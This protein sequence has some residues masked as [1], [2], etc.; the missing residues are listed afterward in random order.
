MLGTNSAQKLVSSIIPQVP[1]QLHKYA[2]N[3]YD[4]NSIVSGISADTDKNKIQSAAF[5]GS[6]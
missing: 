3:T 6:T 5:Y 2:L 1:I 4:V